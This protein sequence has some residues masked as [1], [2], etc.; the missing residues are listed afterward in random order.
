[1][2]SVH[3]YASSIRFN[4]TREIVNINCFIAAINA[5]NRCQDVRCRFDTDFIIHVK[6]GSLFSSFVVGRVGC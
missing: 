3:G 5:I 2:L 6:G 1:M 4:P